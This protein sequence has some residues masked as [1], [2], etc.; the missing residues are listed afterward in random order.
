MIPPHQF[1]YVHI[2]DCWPTSEEMLL[3]DV[4]RISQKG[5]GGPWAPGALPRIE[6][7]SAQDLAETLAP[8][9]VLQVCLRHT[10]PFE[11]REDKICDLRRTPLATACCQTRS[12]LIA[13]LAD[14]LLAYESRWAHYMRDADGMPAR[15]QQALA[16]L[17]WATDVYLELRRRRALTQKPARWH[18]T[19]AR[20]KDAGQTF[21]SLVNTLT[22]A[23]YLRSA[24]RPSPLFCRALVD[25]IR[26]VFTQ[27]GPPR[28]DYPAAAVWHTIAS[29]LSRLGLEEGTE[30]AIAER[31]RK[32]ACPRKPARG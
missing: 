19:Q 5:Y 1:L 9:G 20:L 12:Q 32:R 23:D 15:M 22:P 27:Y 11:G 13:G 10:A 7:P 21:A 26:A 2:A 18:L 29:I 17:R 3:Q 31:L 8:H 25:H 16:D 6:R 14:A 28:R 4:Q 30:D 24:D